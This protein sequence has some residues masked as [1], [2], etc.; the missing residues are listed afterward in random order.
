MSEDIPEDDL[1]DDAPLPPWRE[2]FL[3]RY[4]RN[5]KVAVTAFL[6]ALIVLPPLWIHKRLHREKDH[7][8]DTSSVAQKPDQQDTTQISADKIV[9]TDD[10]ATSLNDQDDRNIKMTQAPDSRVTEDTPE[11]SLPRISEDG[12]RPW[13]IYGRPFNIAD[14]RPRVAVI[15]TGLGMAR[16]ITDE[17]IAQ[18]P[19][20]ITLAF[21]AEGPVTGAWITRARQDGHET[22]LDIPM[23]PFD[24]PR[25][26]PGPG[27]LLTSL[28]NSDNLARLNG[29]MHKSSGFVGITSISGSRFTTDS[30]KLGPVLDVLRQRG[31]MAVDARVAPHAAISDMAHNAG[32]PVATVTQKLDGDLD[33]DAIAAALDNLEKTARL[34]GRAVGIATASPILFAQLQSWAKNLPQRGI[35]LAP[36]SA[37]VQ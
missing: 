32:V 28:P 7:I 29:F 20:T 34:N 11:G 25:S 30:T 6:I 36:V 33:P 31:L 19:P 26:D 9:A 12:L 2:G 10:T 5:T 16:A 8:A 15:I 1:N 24:Y 27:S 13:Q 35:A 18:L 37:M 23:E 4:P 3:A 14:K 22:L 21:D 17:A